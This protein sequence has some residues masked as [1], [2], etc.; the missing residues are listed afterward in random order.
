MI[1]ISVSHQPILQSTQRPSYS[2][3]HPESPA[4]AIHTREFRQICN[5]D[6]RRADAATQSATDRIGRGRSDPAIADSTPSPPPWRFVA[7][8]PVEY[9]VHPVSRL[10]IVE[11]L[12]Q[13]EFLFAQIAV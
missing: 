1:V 6:W 8:S 7:G 13:G 12:S 2:R 3:Q 5:G 4:V 11:R 9:V 10:G